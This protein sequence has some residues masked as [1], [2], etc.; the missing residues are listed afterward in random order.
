M[1]ITLTEQNVKHV[2]TLYPNGSTLKDFSVVSDSV[3]RAGEI[4]MIYE[5]YE[6]SESVLDK[7]VWFI[8]ALF[9]NENTT[10]LGVY[11]NERGTM[12]I[13]KGSGTAFY[14]KIDD[15]TVEKSTI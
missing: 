9:Q 8:P 14:C 13:G 1:A 15:V 5:Q 4:K 3:N 11:G 12:P 10:E 2:L 6:C 7:E